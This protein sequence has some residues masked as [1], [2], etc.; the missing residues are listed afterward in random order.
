MQM[1]IF[2]R[3]AVRDVL[4]TGSIP[5]ESDWPLSQILNRHTDLLKPSITP[6]NQVQEHVDS[7]MKARVELNLLIS[8]VEKYSESDWKEKRLTVDTVG[9]NCLPLVELLICAKKAKKPMDLDPG[10]SSLS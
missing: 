7:Y 3:D 4:K 9:S 8:L 5:S 10:S 2:L 1:T 6:T